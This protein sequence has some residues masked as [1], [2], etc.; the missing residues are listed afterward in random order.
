MA[1]RRR[2]GRPAQA[3]R[4]YPPNP[5]RPVLARQGLRNLQREIRAV[6]AEM[7]QHWFHGPPQ[8]TAGGGGA[9]GARA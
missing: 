7:E 9:G 6:L 4:V 2:V 5:F 8:R 3:L 1:G